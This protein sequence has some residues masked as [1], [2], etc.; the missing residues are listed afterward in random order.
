MAAVPPT[1]A[2]A[3]PVAAPVAAKAAPK[4][5]IEEIFKTLEYGESR[6]CRGVRIQPRH[7]ECYRTRDN[8]MIV[9]CAHHSRETHL[10]IYRIP[11]R[12][13][14]RS[15]SVLAHFGTVVTSSLHAICSFPRSV[16]IHPSLS[17]LHTEK[18]TCVQCLNSVGVTHSTLRQSVG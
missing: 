10:T 15:G 2:K 5:S 18:Q 16:P 11:L 1:E 7:F 8:E 14:G 6:V 4:P 12:V 17:R 9:R 3:E 13:H